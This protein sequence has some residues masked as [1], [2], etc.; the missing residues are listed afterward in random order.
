MNPVKSI[1]LLGLCL[2]AF[3]SVAQSSATDS[4]AQ[5]NAA[6]KERLQRGGKMSPRER[7][8]LAK[9]ER[10][11][12]NSQAGADFLAGN[13][14]KPGVVTLGSGVQYKI[15]QA[16][17]GKKA[18]DASSVRVRYT[19]KLAD[20]STF[21]KAD[22]KT[23]TTL[24]VAGLVPGLKEAVKLMPA[25]SKWEVVIPPQLAYGARGAHGIA[26]NAVL[27][28]VIEVVDVV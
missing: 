15:L 19:G 9:A 13:R 2:L 18:T 16:G 6:N 27:I 11:Q 24:R 12:G 1:A 28:Y 14:A 23:P 7:A 22:D 4:N 20:G 26:P 3:Q 5:V 10:A 25:G 21:D 8:E 17:T